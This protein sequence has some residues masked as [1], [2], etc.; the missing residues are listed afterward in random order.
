MIYA[1]VIAGMIVVADA[2]KPEAALA[3]YILKKMKLHTVLLTGDNRKTAQA[4][5]GQVRS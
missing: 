5:A 2:V 1:D 4:I 3:V